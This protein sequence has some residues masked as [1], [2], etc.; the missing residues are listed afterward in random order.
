MGSNKDDANPEESQ[1]VKKGKNQERQEE[2]ICGQKM[3]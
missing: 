1:F 3:Q 2:S